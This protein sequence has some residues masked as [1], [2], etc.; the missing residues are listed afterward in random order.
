[1]DARPG[2]PPVRRAGAG[3]AG[4]GEDAGGVGVLAATDAPG[5]TLPGVASPPHER[6]RVARTPPVLAG[7]APR[8]AGGAAT[9]AAGDRRGEDAARPPGPGTARRTTDP[10]GEG[11]AGTCDESKALTLTE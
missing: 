2:G 9:G 7:R 3:D 5:P 1:M 8:L 10:G 11:F 4:T 6:P